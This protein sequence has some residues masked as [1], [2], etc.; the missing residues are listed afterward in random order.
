MAKERFADRVPAGALNSFDEQMDREADLRRALGDLSARG[1]KRVYRIKLANYQRWCA[2]VGYQTDIMF[3]T[4]ARVEEYVRYL[5][6]P[7]VRAAPSTIN[8]TI[9]ALAYYAERASVSPM[10]SMR[11]ARNVLN[12]YKAEL[13]RRKLVD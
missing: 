13:K 6:S 3:I 8:Q 9:S 11:P 10:P 5:V 7:D 2:S 1:T 4:D 12:A